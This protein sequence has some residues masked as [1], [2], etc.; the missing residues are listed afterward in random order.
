[1]NEP[2]VKLSFKK[3]LAEWNGKTKANVP[4]VLRTGTSKRTDHHH[5]SRHFTGNYRHKNKVQ[6]IKRITQAHD[7]EKDNLI[8]FRGNIDILPIINFLK[9]R[10]G[11]TTKSLAATGMW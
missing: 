11:L 8:G 4:V 3:I 9:N 10:K 1:M 2:F 5:H 7:E 6:S